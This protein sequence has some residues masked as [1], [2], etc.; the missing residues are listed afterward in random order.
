MTG[1]PLEYLVDSRECEWMDQSLI[2]SNTVCWK[3]CWLHG[4]VPLLVSLHW[5]E[6]G[7]PQPLCCTTGRRRGQGHRRCLGVKKL[8]LDAAARLLGQGY[9]WP[10]TRL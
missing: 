3:D 7:H 9:P 10:E 2:G 6:Q 8:P 4:R 5:R 1:S